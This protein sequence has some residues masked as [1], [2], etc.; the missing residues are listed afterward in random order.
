MLSNTLTPEVRQLMNRRKR[1][2]GQGMTEYIIIVGLI[3]ILMVTAV[4]NFKTA[5]NNAFDKSTDKINNDI[6]KKI[7]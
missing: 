6:T 4:T 5:L 2:R 7:K 3:A 1:Q